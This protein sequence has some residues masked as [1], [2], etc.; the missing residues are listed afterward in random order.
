MAAI[1]W[2][3]FI[4]GILI[5]AGGFMLFIIIYLLMYKFFAKI[6]DILF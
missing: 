1:N 3:A 5:L 2:A 6:F 4:G